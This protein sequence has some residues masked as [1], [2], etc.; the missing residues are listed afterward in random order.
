MTKIDTLALV[1]GIKACTAYKINGKEIDYFPADA[2]T[3]EQVEPVYTNIDPIASLTKEEWLELR[4]ATKEQ[5]P[6]SIRKY[7]KFIED[8]VEIPIT[9][10][11]HGPERNETI[12]F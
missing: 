6:D 12:V 4:N 10:L 11:S 9:I 1:S 7:I 2:P 3:L 5:L 8:F